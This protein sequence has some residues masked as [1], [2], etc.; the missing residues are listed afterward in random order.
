MKST[1]LILAALLL[2]A[3]G[4]ADPAYV[5]LTEANFQSEVLDSEQVVLVDFYADW[6]GPCQKVSPAVNELA[7]DMTGKAVVGKLNTDN[8][9]N[10]IDKYGV[11]GIPTFIVFKG[12][13]EVAR[14]GGIMTKQELAALIEPHL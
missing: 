5:A 4:C 2:T 14:D 1:S 3:V 8:A 11:D 7:S 12:G 13:Q 9:P 10:L 6:C